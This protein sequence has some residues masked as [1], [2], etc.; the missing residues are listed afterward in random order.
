MLHLVQVACQPSRL[1]ERSTI[2]K[3]RKLKPYFSANGSMLEEVMMSS[4]HCVVICTVKCELPH[5]ADSKRR[6]TVRALKFLLRHPLP[7]KELSLFNPTLLD[8]HEEQQEEET[9]ETQCEQEVER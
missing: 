9:R 3:T 7:F 2:P 4:N 8:V 5:R 6:T 1:V